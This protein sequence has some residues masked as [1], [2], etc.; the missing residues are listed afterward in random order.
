MFSFIVENQEV[1]IQIIGLMV[2]ASSR[3]PE[4]AVRRRNMGFIIN[5]YLTFICSLLIFNDKKI[6]SE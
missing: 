3:N 4:D 5:H 1:E 2:H 6:W